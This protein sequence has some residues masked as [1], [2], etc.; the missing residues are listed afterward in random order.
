MDYYRLQN[1]L[2]YPR[3]WFLGEVNFDGEWDFWKYLSAG[4]V[5]TP[6]KELLVTVTEEGIPLDFTMADFEL[7][8]VNEKVTDLIDKDEI[9]LIPI[10]ISGYTSENPYYLM[11]IKNQVDCVDEEKSDF[12]RWEINDP[13]RPD[14]AGQYKT[15]Y[16][17]FVNKEHCNDH[18]IF[19]IKGYNSIIVVSDNLKKIFEKYRILGVKY[20]KIS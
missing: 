14:K 11:V 9:Q 10:K 19:R 17:L 2:H 15:F 5:E 4:E 1:D 6:N 18:N 3:R 12:D 16:K 8:V 20:K 13:I 7:L